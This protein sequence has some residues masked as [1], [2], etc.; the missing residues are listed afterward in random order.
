MVLL[1]P[2]PFIAPGSIV[3]LPAGRPLS[4]TLPVGSAHVGWVM[5]PTVGADGT[6]GTALITTSADAT[7]VQPAAFVTVKLYVPGV[8]PVIVL[9]PP[10]PFIAPGSIVQ[11]PAGR[12]LSTTLP[13]DSAHVG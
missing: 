11:L 3:Q 13:V 12:P 9:L 8:S 5:A 1:P 4:T 2:E 6:P 10:E 7:E